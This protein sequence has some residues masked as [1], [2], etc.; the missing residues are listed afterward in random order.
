[1]SAFRP[2]KQPRLTGQ[3]QVTRTES[4]DLSKSLIAEEKNHLTSSSQAPKTQ[5]LITKTMTTTT[6]EE[7]KPVHPKGHKVRD[8]DEVWKTMDKQSYLHLTDTLALNDVWVQPYKVDEGTSINATVHLLQV[9]AAPHWKTRVTTCKMGLDDLCRLLYLGECLKCD[10]T[11]KDKPTYEEWIADKTAIFVKAKGVDVATNRAKLCDFVL[12]EDES[13]SLNINEKVGIFFRK[14][15]YHSYKSGEKGEKMDNP[16][17]IKCQAYKGTF[18][19]VLEARYLS[20][21]E[22]WD[23]NE[24]L[25]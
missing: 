21:P 19:Y 1:M 20:L 25:C 23:C 11:G 16:C 6:D 8:V 5:S 7:M 2:A 24:E 14:I 22:K 17:M 13:Y 15:C 3:T 12:N 18:E 4:V 9:I 10:I